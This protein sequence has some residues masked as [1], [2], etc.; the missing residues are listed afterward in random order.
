MFDGKNLNNFHTFNS[1][2]VDS[3]WTIDG[4]AIKFNSKGEG[5]GGDL[6]TNKTYENF[7]LA[8]EWKISNC[9]NSGIFFNVQEGENAMKPGDKYWATYQTG[10]EMQILDNTCHPDTRFVT[11][12]AGDLYDMIECKYSTVKPAGQWNRIR[13]ISNNGD[14]QFWMN[15][16]QVVDFKMHDDTWNT[17]VANS[18]FKD[19][20]EFGKFKS[21]HL[22]LQDHGDDVWFRNIKI[23]N[24]K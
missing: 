24:I 18:K 10:P 17:M 22:S 3:K 5:K 14:L 23:R 7:E 6:V 9:G 16:Y 1:D 8:L 20:Q 19:W 2:K 13:I 12:R 21:G 4:D 15:G 11:H